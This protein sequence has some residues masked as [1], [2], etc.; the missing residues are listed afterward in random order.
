[1]NKL[2]DVI[3]IGAGP[4]GTSCAYNIMRFN[5][6]ANV[7]L[8]DKAEFP[9]YK[10]C[11]GGVSPEVSNYLDFDLT[12]GIDLICNSATLVAGG[13]EFTCEK[14]P[15]WMV[16]REKF[17]AFLLDKA[18]LKG[19]LFNPLN[20]V[21]KVTPVADF[22]Q[23]ET[24]NS[25]IYTA[26]IVVLA[27]GGRGNLGKKLGI[28][29][30]NVT[31]AAME[32]EHYTSTLDGKLFID[33]DYNDSGY[34]WNFPKSDGLSLGIG[35][36]LKGRNKGNANIPG[37][38]KKYTEKF[39]VTELNKLHL[40][41]HPILLY[42]G[43]QKLIHDRIMLIGEIAGCVDP[44]TAEG[45]RPAIKNGYL[46]A[47]VIADALTKNDLKLLVRYNRIFHK[48]IG[49]DFYYARIMAY[50]LNLNMAKFLP[51]ISTKSA[52]EGFMSVFSGH[53]S[54]Q[55]K[56]NLRRICKLVWKSLSKSI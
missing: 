17:D 42:S 36:L 48:E 20:E 24:I 38:L 11:G 26:R 45:I 34:A 50:F 55:Q 31:V 29:K 21:I 28:A 35:G 46:A 18:K 52:I 53:S 23:V 1:M 56:I 43:R 54:Y 49:K 37:K 10:A 5:P 14:Y 6:N 27:E 12:E 32:Y 30:K 47:K 41:G 51:M 3:I 33:F 15:L 44:L 22:I 40:H 7:L 25:N 8:L 2:Y 19:V 13:K 16:R 4:A 39:N 9:R